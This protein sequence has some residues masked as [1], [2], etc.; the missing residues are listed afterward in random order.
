MKK[1]IG[2]T[3]KNKR[4]IAVNINMAAIDPWFRPVFSNGGNITITH[5]YTVIIIEK[6]AAINFRSKLTIAIIN[7]QIYYLIFLLRILILHRK[8]LERLIRKTQVF[9]KIL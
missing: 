5:K 4:P 7:H 9:Q 3:T 2:P 8:T 1:T 6:T